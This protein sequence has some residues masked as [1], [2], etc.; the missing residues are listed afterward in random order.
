MGNILNRVETFTTFDALD[1][2]SSGYSPR[3]DVPSV[4]TPFASCYKRITRLYLDVFQKCS[5]FCGVKSQRECNTTFRVINRTE[6]AQL[7]LDVY[8]KYSRVSGKVPCVQQ[9][10]G[11]RGSSAFVGGVGNSLDKRKLQPSGHSDV[12]EAYLALCLSGAG[13]RRSRSLSQITPV[14]NSILVHM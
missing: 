10:T 8:R 5:E 6:D 9:G 14:F 1:N 13:S 7:Y 12:F 11:L 3:C 2:V 4:G